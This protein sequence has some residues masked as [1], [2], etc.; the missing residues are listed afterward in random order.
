MDDDVRSEFKFCCVLTLCLGPGSACALDVARGKVTRF[1]RSGRHCSFRFIQT[2]D[3]PDL[4]SG[5]RQFDVELVEAKANRK[6][7]VMLLMQAHRHGCEL[8]LGYLGHGLLRVGQSCLFL[9]AT[10]AI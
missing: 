4:I 9:S 2:D 10:P 5:C 7:A 3:L 1:S 6:D 8:E